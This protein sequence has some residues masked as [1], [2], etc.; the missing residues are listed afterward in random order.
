MEKDVQK[1]HELV[2]G[3]VRKVTEMEIRWLVKDWSVE[4]FRKKLELLMTVGGGIHRSTI[5][6][7]R[8]DRCAP[9][10]I[11]RG[12]LLEVLG[13]ETI[14]ELGLGYKDEAARN[15]TYMT[16]GEG[17][18]LVHRRKMLKA[19]GAA[20]VAGLLLPVSDL[21]YTAQLLE[22]RKRITSDDVGSAQD[23]ATALAIAYRQNPGPDS[24]RAAKV[25][26]W[27]LLDLL[28][29]GRTTDLAAEA[30]L[31][32]VASDA[33]A[34]AGHGAFHAGR[35]DDP[36]RWFECALGLAREAGDRR[37]EGLALADRAWRPLLAWSMPG[38]N[39]VVPDRAAG[40]A[41]LEGAAAFQAVLRPAGRA[42][43][44]AYLSEQLAVGGGDL[45]S[46][47]LMERARQAAALVPLDDPGW[48]WWS[49]HGELGGWD[50]ARPDVFAGARAFALGRPAEALQLYEQARGGITLPIRRI[51]LHID[52]MQAYAALGDVERACV[53][54]IAAL[55][56]SKAYNVTGRPKRLLPARRS[57]PSGSEALPLVRELD[58]RLRLAA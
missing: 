49:V 38:G 10:A 53:S 50:S 9:Q 37:L 22:K 47:R 23:T 43:V 17:T 46:G 57:F 4:D 12:P 58:E 35:F 21:V 11:F 1:A 20:S 2:M 48:G 44:F 32:A 25:H 5:F 39:D 24:A 51:G 16:E 27:T 34:L 41:A 55:D 31:Q 42:Y 8:A 26:A 30:G 13:A 15:F 6:R 36:D 29:S 45:S 54:G 33:C 52:E 19:A 18:R 40:V 28:K 56:V 14:G 3:D 7:W